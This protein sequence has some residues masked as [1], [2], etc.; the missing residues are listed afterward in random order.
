MSGSLAYC[1]LRCQECP[2][3]LASLADDDQLRE[4]VARRWSRLLGAPLVT[5][6]IDCD[7]C[8]AQGQ[9]RF[10]HCEVCAIRGCCQARGLETCASCADY[11][12]AKLEEFFAAVPGARDNLEQRRQASD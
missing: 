11:P 12:C 10:K 4:V 9:R 8:L 6:E 5:A 7:G 2:V 1:G 3:R